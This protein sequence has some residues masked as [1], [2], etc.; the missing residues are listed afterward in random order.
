MVAAILVFLVIC[1][2]FCALGGVLGIGAFVV[3]E[4]RDHHRMGK[5]PLVA[6]RRAKNNKKAAKFCFWMFL[7]MLIFVVLMEWLRTQ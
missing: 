3:D 4:I 7:G 6:A 1:L 5:D 2:V